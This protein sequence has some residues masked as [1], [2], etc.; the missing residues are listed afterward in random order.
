MHDTLMYPDSGSSRTD[1]PGG[2][3]AELWDSIQAILALPTDARLFVGHDYGRGER[4]EPAW[5]ATVAEHLE[6][7]IHVK[8]GTDRDTFIARRDPRAAPNGCS[9]RCR[10]TSAGVVCRRR[11]RTATVT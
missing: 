7:N 8:A 1:F 3:S 5:E 2:S 4:M 11:N 6:R 9:P 10:S